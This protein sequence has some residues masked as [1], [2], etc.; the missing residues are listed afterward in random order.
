MM[1]RCRTRSWTYGLHRTA[2]VYG[3]VV[4]GLSLLT[5]IILLVRGRRH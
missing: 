1:V 5:L 4:V 2:V 3:L